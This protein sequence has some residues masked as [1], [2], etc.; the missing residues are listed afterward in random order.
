[1][2]PGRQN[3]GDDFRRRRGHDHLC[4]VRER[5]ETRATATIAAPPYVPS[6]RAWLPRCGSPCERVPVSCRPRIRRADRAAPPRRPQ[7]RRSRA[8]TPRRSNR[9]RLARAAARRRV[10]ATAAAMTAAC[11]VRT[12]AGAGHGARLAPEP[13]R[14][15]DVGQV[16]T[17]PHRSAASDPSA[18]KL[19]Q[20]G[21]RAHQ[22]E[23]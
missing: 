7:P 2:T 22:P 3:V 17:S 5:T 13:R 12:I 8:Q 9:P 21:W 16:G 18:P 15:L 6:L 11:L 20:G 10:C 4:P 14:R 1:M 23:G 19:A